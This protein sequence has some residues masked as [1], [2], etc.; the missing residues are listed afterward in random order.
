[1]ENGGLEGRVG[2]FKSSVDG[3]RKKLDNGRFGRPNKKLQGDR[4]SVQQP[5]HAI[6]LSFSLFFRAQIG[7]EFHFFLSLDECYRSQLPSRERERTKTLR[8]IS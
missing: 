7:Q 3:G 5:P 2:Y 4:V 6:L 8:S 1:M